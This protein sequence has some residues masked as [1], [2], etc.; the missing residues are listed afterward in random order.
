MDGW[1]RDWISSTCI[2]RFK[3]K[4]DKEET[5]Q[6]FK[7]KNIHHRDWWNK[8]CHCEAAFSGFKKELNLCNTNEIAGRTLGIAFHLSIE[9]NDIFQ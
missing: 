7:D 5:I 3:S 8:G 1:G 6:N 9:V 2:V 4:T